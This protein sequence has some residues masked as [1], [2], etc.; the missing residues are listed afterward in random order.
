MAVMKIIRR[1]IGRA[2]GEVRVCTYGP[3]T[4]IK[5]W[6]VME[7][8]EMMGRAFCGGYKGWGGGRN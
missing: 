1:L 3:Q 5:R 7:H 2:R 4:G 6:G 8:G